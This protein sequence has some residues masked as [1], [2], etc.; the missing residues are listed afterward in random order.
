MVEYLVIDVL[1]AIFSFF[2]LTLNKIPQKYQ[3]RM[4]NNLINTLV[5][6]TQLRK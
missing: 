3:K 5:A 1:R 6:T 4:I 2:F